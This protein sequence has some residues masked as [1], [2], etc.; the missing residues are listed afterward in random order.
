MRKIII[1]FIIL[2]LNS[3]FGYEKNIHEQSKQLNVLSW[4]IKMMPAPYGWFINSK[5][6]AERITDFILNGERY[7]IILFQE[8]KLLG[9]P[10]S[11]QVSLYY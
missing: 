5:E 10:Q 11:F 3:V 6:R 9:L 2:I 4:N 1:V 7:D 8:I